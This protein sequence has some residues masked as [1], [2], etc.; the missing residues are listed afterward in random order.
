VDWAQRGVATAS[1]QFIRTLGGMIWVSV[2]GGVMNGDLLGRLQRIPGVGART[3]V[4][5]GQWA[6]RLLDPV[7]RAALGPELQRAMQEALAA[8]LRSVH[9]VMLLAALL[10]LATALL[11]PN[12]RFAPER[13][14][15][16]PADL[17]SRPPE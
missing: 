2:M 9:L 7:Q 15:E 6:N 3:A 8:A 13:P 11:L 4:E 16:S 10:S 5:A 1:F 14:Q 17:G 12:L